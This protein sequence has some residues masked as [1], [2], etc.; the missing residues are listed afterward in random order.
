ALALDGDWRALFDLL[1]SARSG[2]SDWSATD[3]ATARQGIAEV[4]RPKLGSA[5]D[6]DG[7]RMPPQAAIAELRRALPA[8]GICTTDVGSH[9]IVAVQ[10]WQ[11]GPPGSFLTS[12]GLS[13]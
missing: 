6:G 8:N 4:V 3:A 5:P 13:P 7:E 2:G 11:A 9:K 10:Q 1:G 12:G